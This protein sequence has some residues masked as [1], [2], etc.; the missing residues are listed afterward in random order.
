MPEPVALTVSQARQAI[1]RARDRREPPGPHGA[2][3]GR[4][5]HHAAS[6]LLDPGHPA[7]WERTL[8]N[9][10][11]TGLARE[12]YDL[13][14]GYELS[15]RQGLLQDAG[16]DVLGLWKAV[17]SYA[18]WFAGLVE[19]ARGAKAIE[20][21]SLREIWVG[22]TDLFQAEVELSARF[23]EQG[24]RAPVLVKGRADQLIRASAG[25]WCVIEFKLGSGHAEADLLQA[26]LYSEMLASS[27][28]GA[29]KPTVA[30]V[31]FGAAGDIEETL[32]SP[33]LAATVRPQLIRLV[34]AL[35]GVIPGAEIPEPHVDAS[36]LWPR[37]PGPEE[38]ALG[39]SLAEAF[40][41][42]GAD[43]RVLGEPVV[44]P[45]FARYFVEPARR[46]TAG[47]V[48]NQGLNLQVR[49][50]LGRAPL[51]HAVEGRIAVDVQRPSREFVPF[52][53]V[54][55]SLPESGRDAGSSR[56][57]AGIGL[58]GAPVFA[59]FS[60]PEQTHILVAGV[61]G[62]GKT[63]WLRVALA[64]LLI[65][66]TPETLRLVLIDP[67]RNAFPELRQSPFL[68][69]PGA[70]LCPP[71][72]SVVPILEEMVREMERRYSLFEQARA[73]DLSGYHQKTVEW[74]P[75]IVCVCDEFADLLL[76]NRKLRE[77]IE[78]AVNRLG[79]KARAAGIHL[80]LATQR[81][82]RQ[83]VSGIL[84]A[85]LPC[86][87][88]LRVTDSLESRIILDQNGAENLLG[89]GDLLFTADG[90]LVRLQSPFLE[91]ADRNEIFR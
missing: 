73:D 14:L 36:L 16:E 19:T 53:H 71:Q 81:P 9:G 25:K 2:I 3:L 68:W 48:M 40:H 33:E 7:H 84:K 64:S 51:I 79:Q 45:A 76:G 43:V 18:T 54:R 83:V 12:L 15:L 61:A 91:E 50:R 31:R 72:D 90:A 59:D 66:N 60:T 42:F 78:G 5:F 74:L 49:L 47:K 38:I 80:V 32:I 28:K 89:R 21:D 17:Q 62:S 55:P 8:A 65:T 75:R 70:F 86:R 10:S 88:A 37:P 58:D 46:V 13:T 69:T 41:E 27:L 1:Y 56:A 23:Q 11:V 22:N 39:R 24:W 77:E 82:S 85:N 44:G 35:A 34:G 30:L 57:L 87:V 63:E 67:K 20:Y 26:C 6:S 29:A 4:L 52:G